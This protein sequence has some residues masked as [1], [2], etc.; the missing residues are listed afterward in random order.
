M[1]LF[2]NGVRG[3]CLSSEAFIN[4]LMRYGLHQVGFSSQ[5]TDWR[6]GVY[7]VIAISRLFGFFTTINNNCYNKGK[8]PVSDSVT[9]YEGGEMRKIVGAYRNKITIH[10]CAEKR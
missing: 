5:L 4:A 8:E 6:I 2:I 3:Y 1:V 9:K 10:E 7:I